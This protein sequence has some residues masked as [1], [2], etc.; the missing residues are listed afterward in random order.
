M[1]RQPAV[2]GQFY[3]GSKQALTEEVDRYLKTDKEPVQA[4]GVVSP[5][6]G[7]IYSGPTAGAVF[8]QTIVPKA[9]IV[10]APNHTGMGATA[11]IMSDGTWEL[12]TGE[13]AIDGSLAGK[14]KASCDDIS[15]DALAHLQEHSLEV[16]LPFLL[17]RQPK[18]SIV[19]ITLQHI[20]YDACE[21]LG[22]AIAA[23]IKDSRQRILIVASSDMN[24]Y[25]E[26]ELTKKK[27]QLAI[28]RVLALDPKG[29]LTTCAQ[30]QISM[31]GVVPTAVMLIAAKELGAT[32]AELISHMTSGDT[33]GDYGSVVG[34]AGIAVR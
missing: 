23:V 4:I 27:D 25:E 13:I 9:C 14:L 15:E 34:Y 11:A 17:A 5:H 12:P 19:P 3:P 22:H 21:R 33:S 18:L 26:H 2:A 30:E 1:I 24:H 8:A 20:R 31:C 10:L 7:Y 6:A 16:Q 28:D 29:L 32:K